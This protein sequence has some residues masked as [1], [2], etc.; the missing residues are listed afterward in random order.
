MPVMLYHLY[1]WMT[2]DVIRIPEWLKGGHSNSSVIMNTIFYFIFS[3]TQ[4]SVYYFN[5]DP[6]SEPKH[7]WIVVHCTY[8]F[9]NDRIHSTRLTWNVLKNEGWLV[10]I[11]RQCY[12]L[13][14][15]WKEWN[16]LNNT[17]QNEGSVGRISDNFL[18]Q[19][20][21]WM[22][23]SC[24]TNFQTDLVHHKRYTAIDW[25]CR[26]RKSKT[27]QKKNLHIKPNPAA[28]IK[29]RSGLY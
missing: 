26:G 12:F 21:A 9:M 8:N 15:L 27:S 25:V 6:L 22:L 19:S 17:L 29:T 18:P 2:C 23:F 5:N 16:L 20:F 14:H 4:N 11:I 24:S 1:L 10:N 3:S 13:W 7:K 28:F